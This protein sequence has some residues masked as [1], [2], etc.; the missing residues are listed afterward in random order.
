MCVARYE[1]E[2]FDGKGDFNLWKAKIKSILGQQKAI[3]AN[4]DPSTLP[5]IMTTDEKET[6]E[7]AAYGTLVLNISNSVLRQVIEEGTTL[8]MWTKLNTLYAA[9]DLPNKMY[10]REKLF[11]YK[12]DSSRSL[13]D[14]L[15]DFKKLTSEFK[16]LGETIGDENEAFLIEK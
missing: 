1:I 13:I 7:L 11:T 14:N 4:Q 5:T 3:K 2:K 10:L 16:N 12:V 9:K 8:K 6:M 15:D